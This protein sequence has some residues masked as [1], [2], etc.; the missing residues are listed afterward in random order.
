MKTLNKVVVAAAAVVALNFT[1]TARAVEPLLTPRAQGNQIHHV[2]GTNNDPDLAMIR[3]LGTPR[4][5]EFAKSLQRVPGTNNDV[6]LVHGPRPTMS[7]RDPRYEMAM[8]Q[9]R[10]QQFQVAPVK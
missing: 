4:Q 8:K 3:P 6:D 7:P 9:L 10:D 1:L 5:V 2:S